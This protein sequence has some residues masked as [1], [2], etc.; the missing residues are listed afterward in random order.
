MGTPL[1]NTQQEIIALLGRVGYTM[2]SGVHGEHL[3]QHTHIPHVDLDVQW[4]VA[5]VQLLLRIELERQS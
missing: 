4:V 1:T 5:A 3:G 2:G